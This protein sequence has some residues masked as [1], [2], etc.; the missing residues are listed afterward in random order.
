MSLILESKLSPQL[1]A[2]VESFV[3]VCVCVCLLVYATLVPT[4]LIKHDI[5]D[6]AGIGP[7]SRRGKKKIYKIVNNVYMKV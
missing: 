5:F 4:R 3:C 2:G 7:R 1:L 6:I